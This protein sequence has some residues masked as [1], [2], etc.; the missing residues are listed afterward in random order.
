MDAIN[1]HRRL[2]FSSFATTN[3]CIICTQYT[4]TPSHVFIIYVKNRRK[5][6]PSEAAN[7]AWWR[8]W[9]RKEIDK[10]KLEQANPNI[11]RKYIILSENLKL[12]LGWGLQKIATLIASWMQF[13]I[14]FYACNQQK[15]KNYL[16][17]L[18]SIFQTIWWGD[19][20][21]EDADFVSD[22]IRFHSHSTDGGHPR[23][24]NFVS[25]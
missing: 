7:I 10:M 22:P 18:W 19:K 25:G 8:R 23:N 13:I 16:H 14:R 1:Y 4:A 2:H 21:L 20:I 6:L 5:N 15:N 3:F 11:L 9:R 12:C 24:D 17:Q